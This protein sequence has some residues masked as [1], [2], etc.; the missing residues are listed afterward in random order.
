[1]PPFEPPITSIKHT[2]RI[3]RNTAYHMYTMPLLSPVERDIITPEY[4]RV[5][6]LTYE[7]YLHF[8]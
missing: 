8:L 2:I 5:K 6:V 1:M 3:I 4:L 7:K